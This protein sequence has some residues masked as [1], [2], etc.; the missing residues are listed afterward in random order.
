MVQYK[1]SLQIHDAYSVYSNGYIASEKLEKPLYGAM[2]VIRS[3]PTM[4][5][6]R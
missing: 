3:N 2:F 1:K 5:L 6:Q 4:D